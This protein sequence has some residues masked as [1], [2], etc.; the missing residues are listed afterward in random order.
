MNNTADMDV[1]LGASTALAAC[2]LVL[3]V[4]SYVWLGL[5]FAQ[6]VRA[7]LPS[8]VRAMAGR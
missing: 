4:A 3:L 1:T 5:A 7:E 6:F 2:A 8:A